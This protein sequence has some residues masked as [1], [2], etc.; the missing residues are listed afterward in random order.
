ML[1]FEKK[2]TDVQYVQ[3]N[4]TIKYL[5]TLCCKSIGTSWPSCQFFQIRMLWIYDIVPKRKMEKVDLF[6][7]ILDFFP[8]FSF[9]KCFFCFFSM[10]I[11]Q[12]L[13]GNMNQTYFLWLHTMI[14][15]QKLIVPILL[16]HRMWTLN[17]L[18][19]P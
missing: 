9:K 6:P 12:N 11:R 1:V 18:T 16:Q 17:F 13:Y 14:S 7:P 19:F 10:Q 5:R 2:V 3:N 15:S 4:K 8:F